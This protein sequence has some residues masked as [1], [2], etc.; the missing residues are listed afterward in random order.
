M[1]PQE[2]QDGLVVVSPCELSE[3]QA[4]EPPTCLLRGRRLLF[5]YNYMCRGYICVG[6]HLCNLS[7]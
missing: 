1:L 3:G 5:S 4:Y 2:F 7:V 6:P